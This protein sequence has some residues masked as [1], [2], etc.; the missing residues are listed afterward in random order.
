MSA[1]ADLEI[2]LHHWEKDSYSIELRF[3]Q[4]QS[5]AEKRL[6]SDGPTVKIDPA[7]FALLDPADP[8]YG[9]LL[10]SCLFADP[11]VQREFAKVRDIAL[12]LE[13]P[14]HVRLFIGP[15]AAS[16]H[17]LHWETLR[18][19]RPPDPRDV[20]AGASL[21]TDQRILFSRYMMSQEYR[22]VAPRPQGA[23]LKTLVVI[24][25]GANLAQYHL[26]PV[27]AAAEEA[28]ARA[29]LA[30]GEVT[31]LSRGQATLDNLIEQA[32]Q[33]CDVLYLVCHGTLLKQGDPRLWLE[34]AVGN[35]A[36]VAGGE[37]V[38]RLRELEKQPRLVVLASCQSAGAGDAAATGDKGVLA[39]LGP[40]LAEAG[41]PAVLAMQGNVTM[42]TLAQFLPAFFRDL[43]RDG[44][45]D[46]AAAKARGA[47]R[48]RSDAW[49]PVLFMR[50]RTGRLWYA[51]GLEGK[52]G[53]DKWDGL[54]ANIAEGKCTP[55]LGSGLLE[56]MLGSSRDIARRWADT[57]RFP[58]E[59]QNREDLPQV[60]QF[61][62]AN[63]GAAFPAVELKS[64]LRRAVLRRYGDDLS[65]ATRKAPLEGM[66]SAAGELLRRKDPSEPHKVLASLPCPVFFT[67][68]PDDLLADA[69]REAGKNPE[70][71]LCRW[72]QDQEHADEDDEDRPPSVLDDREYRPS[73]GRP[74][75]YHLF[76]RLGD[77]D[78]DL[79]VLT[80]DG[81]FDYLIGVHKNKDVIPKK[82]RRILVDSGL[83]FLGFQ[84]NDWGFRV[85]FRHIMGLEGGKLRNQV[86]YHHVAVQIDPEG[87]RIM[88]PELA[89]R[90]LESFFQG[91]RI[92]IYWGK[93]EKFV[94]EL[95]RHWA[96]KCQRDGLLPAKELVHD[97]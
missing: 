23:P 61:L 25:N 97:H 87:G 74:L 3:S 15:G 77:R 86:K 76:G 30:G 84:M 1:F 78:N 26:A 35:V 73:E 75:V 88:E 36:V 45:I 71:E 39:A 49:M 40:R 94:E 31:V 52:A 80:E 56:P 62:A 58:M 95:R 37:L 44:Q 90:Y 83:L 68:N 28:R 60:A 47:V 17:S 91:A 57:Y 92:S 33:G 5:E 66:L 32:G 7:P 63:Y 10:Y 29:A 24:G 55:I 16:L 20:E 9:G 82:L 11:A 54:L 69:L 42:K 70:V 59:P 19:P 41:V 93:T 4:S 13:V 8:A 85:L 34:D 46:L 14:L 48:D 43:A 12:G 96:E 50:L 64:Y 53:F 51:E 72:N 38:T 18:D 21:V 27:D 65:E 67:T 79:V 22:P 6:V 81:Y 89:R 2:G